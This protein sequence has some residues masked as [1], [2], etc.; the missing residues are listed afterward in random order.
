MKLARPGNLRTR[1]TGPGA[2][3]AL[4]SLLISVAV[5]TLSWPISD[6]RAQSV[7]IAPDQLPTASAL[8]LPLAVQIALQSNPLVRATASGQEMASAQINEARSTRYPVVQFNETLT[9]SNNPVFVFGSLLEQGRFAAQ[10]FD[11]GSLNAPD[12]LSNFRT[13]LSFRV[14][15]FDQLQSATRINQA[16]IGK[17]QVDSR[18]EMVRQ[19]VRFEVLKAYYGVIVA[20]AK[21]E[22]AD[23]AVRLAQADVKRIRDLFETGMVVQSD[24]L[25]AQVQ[26]AE[27]QQ[28]QIATEGDSTTARAALNTAI[29]IAIDT[30]QQVTGELVDKIF[31]AGSQE[32][33]IRTAITTRPEMETTRLA[34]KSAQEG[35]RGARAEFLP[36]VDAFGGFGLS[37]RNLSSG[38]S[39]YT[40]GAS[41]TF[42]IFDAGRKARISQARAAEAIAAANEEHQASQ[43]RFEVVRA[44]QQYISAKER[45]AVASQTVDQAREALRIVKDR[46]E[47]GL[48]TITEVLRAE[49]TFVRA[50][51]TLLA[52]RYDH[53]IGYG[54]VLLAAGRLV[55]VE[56]FLS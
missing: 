9:R 50:R 20:R 19:Q 45:T 36:R 3:R 13:S 11:L 38:S 53:Y 18:L 27:F 6:V 47:A 15:L 39:D 25:A 30:P 52:A 22:V 17:Q 42:N 28:Q 55:D 48:T 44:Y 21:K 5:A 46:Y 23:E 7:S 40:V 14:P 56:P 26:L 24:L 1:S 35:S 37:G 41:V 16:E 32:E 29:G 10:N 54:N 34:L 51:L 33:L 2:G 4:L 31:P 12:S 49:T 8:T 43:I